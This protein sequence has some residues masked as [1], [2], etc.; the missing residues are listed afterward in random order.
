MKSIPKPGNLLEKE[1]TG[2]VTDFL[3]MKGWTP[4]RLHT[5]TTRAK[6]AYI[7][8]GKKGRLDW[9]MVHPAYPSFWCE[10]KRNSGG[11]ISPEQEESIALL[12]RQGYEVVVPASIE[13]FKLWHAGFMQRVWKR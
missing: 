3:E 4:I 6:G 11:K 9:V 10:M 8:H 7:R 2:Q 5:G 1:V 12:E 13:E